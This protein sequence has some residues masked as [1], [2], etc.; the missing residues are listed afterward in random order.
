MEKQGIMFNYD[1]DN[2]LHTRREIIDT[3]DAAYLESFI[4]QY[5]G[6][7]VTDFLFCVNALL[8]A[9]PSKVFT[10][11]ADRYHVT[12]ERGQNVDYTNTCCNSAKNQ[13]VIGVLAGLGKRL[14]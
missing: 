4:D 5:T 8:S 12:Q 10:S 7:Q 13:T 3:V 2:F 1:S 9:Y 6:T 11:Y 14:G